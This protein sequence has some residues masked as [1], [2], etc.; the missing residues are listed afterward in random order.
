MRGDVTKF[1]DEFECHVR[2][3]K[4]DIGLEARGQVVEVRR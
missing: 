1:R 2:E 3:G 4:C